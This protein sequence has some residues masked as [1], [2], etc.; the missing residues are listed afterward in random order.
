MADASKS[1]ATFPV[2]P[3]VLN[4]PFGQVENDGQV[5]LTVSGMQFMQVMW[6]A[7]Q[8]SGGLIDQSAIAQPA[9]TSNGEVRNRIA[10]MVLT[11]PPR[12]DGNAARRQAEQ[13]R[14]IL[15]PSRDPRLARAV[16][17]AAL[18]AMRPALPPRPTPA[19]AYVAPPVSTFAALPATPADGARAFITDGS[20]PAAA[21]FGAV[22]AGAGANHVPVYWDAGTS[23]WR[24]G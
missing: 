19:P 1:K 8:G 21:N 23:A 3:P 22:A 18:L 17:D 7:I 20:L 16:Q 15:P 14:L 5:Y 13:S 11:Q 2:P 24:I 10:Q 9:T 6:A 12:S 4:L